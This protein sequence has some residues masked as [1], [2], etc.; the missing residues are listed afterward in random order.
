MFEGISKKIKI[1]N[2]TNKE[3]KKKGK[4]EKIKKSKGGRDGHGERGREEERFFLNFS[5]FSFSLRS[6][7]IGP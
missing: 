3:R 5:S 7:E 6:T 2:K 4:E 1:K